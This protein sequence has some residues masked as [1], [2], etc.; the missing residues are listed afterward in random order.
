MKKAIF[1]IAILFTATTLKAQEKF[2]R[3]KIYTDAEGLKTIASLGIETE[4]GLV[5][6]HVWIISELSQTE[7]QKIKTAGFQYEIITED[8]QKSFLENNQNTVSAKPFVQSLCNTQLTDYIT[9]V[10]FSLGSMGGHLYYQEMLNHLDS[11]Q[12][13]YPNLITLRAPVDSVELTIEGRPVYYVKISDNP[14]VN[15]PEPEILY[16]GVHHAREPLS[17]HQL[18][19]YMWY[20][21][22]NYQ[23]D[24]IVR[25]IVNNTELYFIPCLNPDGYIY[26]E[27]VQP[28]GG[29]MWRK[30]RRDNLDG[31]FGV[32]LN[33]NYDY[34]WGYDDFG[35]SPDGN[36]ETY[37]GTSGFSEP[38][39][40]MVRKFVNNHNFKIALNHHAFGNYLIYPWSYDQNIY[41][42]DSALFVNFSQLLTSQNH[43]T[44]GT[45]NQTVGYLVNGN[46]DDWLYGEQSAK[47]KIIALTS[48]VGEDFWPTQFEIEDL[49]K[50]TMYQNLITAQ[51]AGPYAVLHE[52]SPKTISSI[53]GQ[54][55]YT[56]Q[57]LG[58][59]T[60]GSYFVSLLPLSPTINL[61]GPP[62][63]FSGLS[64]MQELNDSIA[65]ELQSININNGDEI[66]FLLTINNG[67]YTLSD[68]IIKIF[69]PVQPVYS[70][71][72]S[73][74]AGWSVA[75]GWGLNSQQYYSAPSSITDSPTGNY[76]SNT[77]S[78]LT[79]N[80]SV[81]LTNAVYA[82][83]QFYAK[84][85]IEPDYDYA[86]VLISND[87]GNTWIPLCGNY[88]TAGSPYQDYGQPV[89]HG[90]QNNWVKE[91]IDLSNFTGH[92]IRIRFKIASDSY[93]QYDGF[94]VD[95][96]VIRQIL[97]GG[98]AIEDYSPASLK[99]HVFPNPATNK[100][101]LS[102]SSPGSSMIIISDVSG[103]QLRKVYKH[104]GIQ[105]LEISL[106]DL[107]N[108]VYFWKMITH[109]NE[110]A[111]GKF[112]VLK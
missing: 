12:S 80:T 83:L 33:R 52:T 11:M 69:G 56:L 100:I 14:L 75:S 41:T 67:L 24:S 94:Y 23:S 99:V 16:T 84:W 35:S 107:Q 8:V 57:Q 43:F 64:F 95:D 53:H 15:E 59:D 18:I 47:P 25:A 26:N 38:E 77:T 46:S 19:Y 62:K 106:D 36:E 72:F 65:Y 103:R 73:S 60:T 49:C 9:P 63:L 108:G 7:I 55:H 50:S 4:H 2:S 109:T 22:E 93:V 70:T 44:Y 34:M 92:T 27:V 5:R 102:T 88:T 61:T 111:I 82:E 97:P 42:P 81:D 37:R 98:L 6:P 3:I 96:M 21:L 17:M 105:P 91:L 66:R 54:I 30:N 45:A 71:D 89:Y 32:D 78:T 74:A 29:G 1:L 90:F 87:N 10:N 31:S 39:T 85:S 40:D 58:L 112:I 51:L 13:L 20:L 48:E 79:Q 104:E 28:A 76:P 86:Q 101:T 68:T 110:T